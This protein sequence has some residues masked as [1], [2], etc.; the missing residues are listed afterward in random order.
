MI[1]LNTLLENTRMAIGNGWM[2]KNSNDKKDA[3]LT[4]AAVAFLFVMLRFLVSGVSFDVADKFNVDF[5]E[6]DASLVAAVIAPTLGSYVMRRA[7]DKK[8][9]FLKQQNGETENAD[10]P[11]E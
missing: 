6:L 7:T 8:Y 3:V 1:K 10:E 4:F 9:L 11:K 5:G 2:M